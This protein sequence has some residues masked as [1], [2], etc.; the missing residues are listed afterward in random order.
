M[1]FNHLLLSFNN[2]AASNFPWNE[3]ILSLIAV[4]MILGCSCTSVMCVYRY[5]F[6]PS[7]NQCAANLPK[8]PPYLRRKRVWL[9]TK[10]SDFIAVWL[11]LNF[12]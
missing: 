8:R 4:Q 2:S 5:A 9:W 7:W 6:V 1:C 10:R 12:R 11:L 3:Y